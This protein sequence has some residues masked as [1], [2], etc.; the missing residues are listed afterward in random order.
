MKP[1][2][3]KLAVKP[4]KTALIAVKKTPEKKCTKRVDNN[5]D[6]TKMRSNDCSSF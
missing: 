5:D 6:P 2:G 4:A 1:L 3:P